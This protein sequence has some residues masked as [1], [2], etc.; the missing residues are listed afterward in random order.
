M[1]NV[2]P[3]IFKAYDI[4][5][6]YPTDIN[7][8]TFR[9]VA[10]AIF[11]FFKQKLNKDQFTIALGR[12]M[13]LSSPSLYETVKSTLSQCGAQVVELGLVSTPTF[14]FAVSN[15]KYDTGIQIT[16]SHNPKEY[17]GMK[18]VINTP[19]GLLKIGKPTGM[20]DIKQLA[21]EGVNVPPA[22]GTLAKKEHI[23][24]DEVQNALK[25]FGN[26]E[27]K[28]LKVVA[29]TA[30]AMGSVYIDELA[31][32]LPISLTRM[33]FELD[34]SFPV[35]QADPMQPEN[36]ADLEKRVVEEKA[37]IGL[38]PDGDGDRMFIIDETGKVV[39]PSYI[40]SIMA[41]EFLKKYPGS[42]FVVDQKYYFTV[43]DIVEENGGQLI[44]S[45][46]GHAYITETM[47]KNKAL[48][49]GE[50]SAHYY[51]SFTGNAESQVIT[52]IGLLKILSETGKK[53][54][55]LVK[56]VQ[57]SYE[58]GEINFET[59]KTPEILEALKQKYHDGEL[60]TMDGVAITYSDWRVGVRSSNT[61]PLLRL[62]IEGRTKEKVDEMVS[63]IKNLII[64]IGAKVKSGGH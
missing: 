38:A 55:D 30:N 52:I 61:E 3:K 48:Y 29:D 1:T 63:E 27:I 42:K 22:Q 50:A 56:E 4:R 32:E 5:G 12:D 49:A 37:D 18:F 34:G 44:L 15:Y 35:H 60:S 21:T 19:D 58:S 45:K 59:E 6:I 23:V 2:N 36:V 40:T 20:E 28:P 47:T 64:Q 26:P 10:K 8:D 13:R 14:Y 16:A 9:E 39:S 41:R 17:A 25:I 43:K 11:V 46:T 24:Q 53:L 54:T 57:R 31:K 62:N 33:N 51:Y 7:E